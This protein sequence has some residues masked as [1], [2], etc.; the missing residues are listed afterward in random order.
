MPFRLGLVLF[1][2]CMPAGLFAAAD[3]VRAC[4][5]RAGRERM[6]VTWVGTGRGDVPTQGGPSLRAEASLGAAGCDAWLLPGLWLASTDA[7][8]AALQV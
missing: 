3:M 2:G 1:P 4:N 7:L 5:L 6:Q 8:D